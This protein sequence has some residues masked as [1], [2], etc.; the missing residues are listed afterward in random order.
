MTIK[1]VIFDLDN[2]L[3]C[4]KTERLYKD[5][6]D[7]LVELKNKNIKIALASYNA[8]ADIVLQIHNIDMF[9]DYIFYEDSRTLSITKM[10]YKYDYKEKMLTTLIKLTE[11]PPSQTLFI[12]DQTKNLVVA[13]KM[14]IQ[15][16]KV[17]KVVG[18]TKTNLSKYIEIA[19]MN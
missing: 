5:V 2:T 7:I 10:N 9:F 17:E 16:C 19:K 11:I 13:S 8:I 14:G 6:V 12:D 18:I 3:M 1:F 15:T 4:S